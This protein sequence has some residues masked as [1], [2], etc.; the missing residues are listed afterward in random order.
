M[1]KELINRYV[2]L[3]DTIRRYGR[4]SRR[5]LDA[6]W[7]R[8]AFGDGRPMPR[9]TFYNYRMGVEQLFGL[10]IECDSRTY[11]YYIR[12]DDSHDRSVTDWLLDSSAMSHV[13]TGARDVAGKIFLEEVPSS[14]AYL[15]VVI[16]ALRE[17]R[18]LRFDYQSYT[19]SR[20]ASGI[21]FEP[22]LLKIFRQRWYV[23]GRNVA[24]DRIKTYALDRMT[25]C[26]MTTDVFTPD[27]SFD[28]ESYF[29]DAFGIVV[30]GAE[31][32]EVVLRTDTRQAK[33]FRALPLHHSQEEMVHDEFS[34]FHYRLR[35]TDDFIAELLSYGPRIQVIS[36]PE[37]KARLCSEYQQALALYDSPS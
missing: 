35:L 21:V 17:N 24:E 14:R 2:W 1:S 37:L 15:G 8:S 23:A 31:P 32:R 22:Y 28:C 4:I 6:C 25:A 10:T 12:E 16:D 20:P 13:L 9:R 26:V 7:R 27:A 30:T 33:Y 19:R 5:D 36:P 18:R 34:D 11:E 29:H 3:V